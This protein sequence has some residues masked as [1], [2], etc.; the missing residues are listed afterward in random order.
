VFAVIVGVSKYE[1]KSINLKFA[2]YDAINFYSYIA[3]VNKED[4]T[5]FTLLTNK[6]ATKDN[7][8]QALEIQF[9]KAGAGDKII[10]FFSGHGGEGYFV[11]YD[12]QNET[13]VL[14]YDEVRSYFRKSKC[15]VKLC[16]TDACYSGGLKPK[17]TVI[18]DSVQNNYPNQNNIIVF[19][20]S[21]S[22]EISK[23]EPKFKNGVFTYYLVYGLLGYADANKDSSI[24]AKELFNYVHTKVKI[25]TSNAQTPIM[26]GKFDKDLV[27]ANY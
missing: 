8:L 6:K 16:F 25:H 1:N 27:I 11:P 19:N 21:K 24:T 12:C 26:F 20:S 22:D 5:Q 7:I 2:A 18:T 3:K 10:F 15:K 17:K 9:A 23:E 14:K 4:S 13:Q